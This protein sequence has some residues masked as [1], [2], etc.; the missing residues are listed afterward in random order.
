M[1]SISVLL[2]AAALAG[3][4]GL[5]PTEAHRYFVLDAPAVEQPQAPPTPAHDAVL[6]VAPTS[7]STFYD[8]QGMAF[9]RTSGQ[10]AYYQYSSWSEPPGRRLTT[11]L[12]TTIERRGDYRV[13]AVAGSGIRGQLLLTTHLE[14]IYHEASALPG[15]AR[16]TLT[17]EL[18]DLRHRALIARRTF[19]ASAPLTSGDAAG[20]ATACGQALGDVLSQ[21]AAWAGSAPTS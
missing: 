15:T 1:R 20:A 10:L 4:A 12:A 21:V 7:V 6:L 13:V 2:L 11:L 3:C 19:S 16:V 14:E 9:S 17:A 18:V 8:T 5:R